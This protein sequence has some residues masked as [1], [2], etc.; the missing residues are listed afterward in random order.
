MQSHC[1]IARAG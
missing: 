1:W